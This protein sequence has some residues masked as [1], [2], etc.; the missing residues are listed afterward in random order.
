MK[1]K[2]KSNLLENFV[3]KRT[4]INVRNRIVLAAMTNK[5][6]HD[7]GIISDNEIRWLALRAK[8]GFGIIT[9]AAAHVSING[10]GWEGEL[11]VFD[12][13]HIDR[14]QQLTNIIQSHGSI[15]LAQLFH[16]GMRSPEIITGEQPI[17][18]SRIICKESKSGF[19]RPASEEDIS[20]IIQDF[21]DAAIR[22][23]K[24]GFDGIELHGAHGYLLSQFLGTKTNLRRDEWGGCIKNR[25][26]IL[27]KIIRSIK[28][29]VPEPFIIGV[30]ISPEI[31]E[32]GIKLDDSIRLACLLRDEDIDYI[33]LSCWDVF[34]NSKSHQQSKKTLT[35]WFIDSC[36]G[37][38][39][40]ISTG[41]IWSASDAK[42]TMQQGA[43]FIGVA[44]AGLAHPDWAKNIIDQNYNP[45]KPPYTAS[46]LKNVGLGEDFIE[47]MRN[48]KGFVLDI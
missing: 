12:D 10:Q 41:N 18:A 34:A 37:I 9:T 21:T 28:N 46:Y 40:V 35:E 5:Q 13:I 39:P 32:I 16:G 17:S 30:R 19:T 45:K 4:K 15:I 25:F 20:K 3:F 8:G 43:K 47:Y 2:S 48:W 27:S 31:K 11:G 42:K 44:R 24:S 26:R 29:N 14:L 6:S 38:P 22:C 7:N 33:H 36:D 23:A 1:I